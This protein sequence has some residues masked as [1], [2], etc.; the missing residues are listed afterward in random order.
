MPSPRWVVAFAVLTGIVARV[1]ADEADDGRTALVRDWAINLG[2][3]PAF[4]AVWAYQSPNPT[5][6]SPATYTCS[7]D[8]RTMRRDHAAMRANYQFKSERRFAPTEVAVKIEQLR[9]QDPGVRPSLSA[10]DARGQLADVDAG[11]TSVTDLGKPSWYD[12][13]LL[14]GATI[15]PVVAAWWIV[16]H[17][18]ELADAR[19]SDVP[20]TDPPRFRLDFEAVPFSVEFEQPRSSGLRL[21]RLEQHESGRPDAVTGAYEFKDF[22]LMEDFGSEVPRQRENYFPPIVALPGGGY[23]QMGDRANLRLHYVSY[24]VEANVLHESPDELFD[25]LAVTGLGDDARRVPPGAPPATQRD[26]AGITP[27][28]RTTWTLIAVGIALCASGI[29]LRIRQR[30]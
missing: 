23:E 28:P 19:V 5:G 6:S 10:V 2:T 25:V 24:L 21:V 29:V 20:G 11:W 4:R 17:P 8:E 3:I 12:S 27:W 14:L 22:V 13:R 26:S 7:L 1:H 30:S 18:G 16:D 9:L 15:S